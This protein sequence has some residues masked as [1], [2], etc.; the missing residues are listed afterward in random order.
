MISESDD[1]AGSEIRAAALK[2]NAEADRSPVVV[3]AGGGYIAGKILQIADECGISIYHD[4]SAATLLS[5]LNLGQEIPPELYQM[6]AEI[7]TA[8]LTASDALKAEL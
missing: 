2:Y 1:R 8:I 4:D 3:A 6:V 5:R 7:Y